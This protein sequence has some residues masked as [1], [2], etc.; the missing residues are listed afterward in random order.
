MSDSDGDDWL[1]LADAVGLLRRQIAEAQGRAADA[2]LR[3]VVGEIRMEF[4]LELARTRGG[5]GELRFAVGSA[6]LR[7]ERSSH[8]VQR[9]SLTLRP[10]QASGDV[11]IN[12]WEG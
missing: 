5:S 1:D 12:D 9:V 11:L 6:G 2:D 8:T 4:E 10:E 3:F 7:R